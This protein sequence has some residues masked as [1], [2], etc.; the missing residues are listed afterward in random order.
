MKTLIQLGGVVQFGIL[1]AS[2]LTPGVLE[3]RRHLVAVPALLRQLFWVYGSFIVFVIVSFGTISLAYP[4]A[5]A[6]GEPLARAMCGMIAIFWS[7]RLAVQW[8][9]FEATP[10]LTNPFLK[11]GYHV[12]T[13]AFIALT[14]IYGCAAIHPL[15][16]SFL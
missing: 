10:F 11:L 6:S 2:A 15:Q 4:S 7:A 3:W 1:I 8:F 12:L 16:R 5:L 14:L 9:V 13:L